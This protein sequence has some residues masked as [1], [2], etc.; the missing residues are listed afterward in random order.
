MSCNAFDNWII[1]G[2]CVLWIELSKD[3]VLQFKFLV[4]RKVFFQDIPWCR[5]L[6]GYSLQCKNDD[7]HV[8]FTSS[9]HI[10]F[11]FHLMYI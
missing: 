8:F 11:I 3:R 6:P 9:C 4:Q 2:I 10:I 7:E 1:S 5:E